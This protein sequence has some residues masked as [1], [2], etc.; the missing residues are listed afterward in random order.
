MTGAANSGIKS[1]GSFVREMA[2]S[3]TIT[4]LSM[5]IVTGR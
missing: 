3:I 1:T 5:N 4:A 2:P